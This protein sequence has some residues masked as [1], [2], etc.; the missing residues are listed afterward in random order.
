[1]G[2]ATDAWLEGI[3]R[4][5]WRGHDP[6]EVPGWWCPVCGGRPK[7]R[8]TPYGVKRECC[9]LWAWG[10]HAPLVDAETHQAR[11]YAHKVFDSLWQSGLVDRTRAYALLAQELGI[12]PA[13]CHMKLMDKQTAWRV[14]SAA[15]RI[16]QR[17]KGKPT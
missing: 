4:A 12:D 8:H 13:D 10:K 5:E 1:M 17:L 14:P 15:H 9:G 3:E 11:Q 2:D 7:E 6:D 16:G